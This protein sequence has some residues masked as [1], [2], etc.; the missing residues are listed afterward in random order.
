MDDS[1]VSTNAIL[2]CS[3]GALAYT[4]SEYETCTASLNGG[5]CDTNHGDQNACVN[6]LSTTTGIPCQYC[7]GGCF[8]SSTIPFFGT[9][10]CQDYELIDQQTSTTPDFYKH[11]PG[12]GVIGNCVCPS[13]TITYDS[14][15]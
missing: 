10:K 4:P 2:A 14:G 11:V 3:E 1:L 7:P 13:I 12:E 8:D 6:S 9:L 5:L 15:P